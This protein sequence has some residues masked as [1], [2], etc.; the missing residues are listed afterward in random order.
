MSWSLRLMKLVA[1][2]GLVIGLGACSSAG[3]A[4]QVE[5]ISSTLDAE[6]QHAHQPADDGRTG[7]DHN[8]TREA[9]GDPS[10]SLEVLVDPMSGWNL[11]VTV[12]GFR[13]APERASTGHVDGEG[14]MHLYV[15]G[16]KVG[17]LYGL[18]HH[19]GHLKPGDHEVRIE[20]SSNDHATLTRDGEAI[21]AAVVVSVDEATE[22]PPPPS[23]DG[24]ARPG[25]KP[26]VHEDGS[27]H[28][29]G[30]G[31]PKEW[32]VT[33]SSDG[34]FVPERL[35]IV[36]GDTVT[37]V[38]ESGYGVW[39]AS[40]IH[41]SHA[42]YPTFDPLGDIP[43]GESWSFR[44]TRNG[45]WR[46]HNHSL[47]SE[48]G[49]IVSSGAPEEALTPL[50]LGAEVPE[51]PEPPSGTNPVAILNDLDS[52]ELFVSLYGPDVAVHALR[53]AT[54]LTGIRCHDMA[55]QA[56][57]VSYQLFGA[58]AFAITPHECDSG[59]IHGVLEA[60]FAERGTAHLEADMRTVCRGM[61]WYR[62]NDCYHGVGHGIMAWS[63]YELHESLSIC[64]VLDE[65][66]REPC[67]A[68]VFMENGVAGATG[69]SDHQS[70]YVS[71][72][73]P[74]YPCNE[75]ARRYV[76]ACYD[77]QPSNLLLHMK[78]TADDLVEFC[79]SGLMG[80]V[81]G[82]CV[83]SWASFRAN[84][85]ELWSDTAGLAALCENELL[86]EG[87]RYDCIDGVYMSRFSETASASVMTGFCSSV[88]GNELLGR[89]LADW[90]WAGLLR[91]APLVLD[92]PVDLD[93]FCES[94]TGPDR[95]AEC[96]AVLAQ[97]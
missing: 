49:V 88:D 86:T 62:A 47:A 87:D 70:E 30:A 74:H 46:Y 24:G 56:G 57:R 44:F 37:F 66:D 5:S 15:D 19:I 8:A 93:V 89:D 68:G 22:S 13:L 40:N 97:R 51:F 9:A 26:H 20:L 84:S 91:L 64:D 12:D 23:A 42:I 61:N 39:P 53:E 69:L 29:H 7:H 63:G 16:N 6:D 33:Y 48:T 41:P 11:H 18:W 76:R 25:E 38:N 72:V 4:P 21:S 17:R 54:E 90:C 52:L 83:R 71:V 65:Q 73:D 55:H 81:R 79:V 27:A 35:E 94:I 85:N 50:E 92:E 80:E 31:A 75:V 58:A 32:V 36:T 95:R 59:A 1:A 10:V 28:T 14:H 2:V 82:L 34:L 78:L 96:A 60:L 43:S 3:D 45:T 77:W 67:Y